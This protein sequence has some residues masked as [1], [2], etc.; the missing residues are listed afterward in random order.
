MKNAL[1]FIAVYYFVCILLLRVLKFVF[2]SFTWEM[3]SY[4]LWFYIGNLVVGVIVYPIL[5]S[6]FDKVFINPWGRIGI[7]AVI[8]LLLLNAIP[9]FTDYEILTI[10][11]FR[12]MDSINIDNNILIIH[13]VSLI[14]FVICYALI[15][16]KRA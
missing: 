12:G 14:S 16:W 9:I 7:A 1:K 6:E 3:F 15:S 13:V 5:K 8:C 2:S 4:L 11:L 10:E